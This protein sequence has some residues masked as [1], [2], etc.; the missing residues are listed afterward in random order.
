[1]SRAP[2]IFIDYACYHIIT[3]GNQ[4]QIIFRNEDNFHNYLKMLKKALK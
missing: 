4:K 1:M 3:R 2:R